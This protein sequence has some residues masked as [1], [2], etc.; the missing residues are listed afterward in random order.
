[1]AVSLDRVWMFDDPRSHGARSIMGWAAEGLRRIGKTVCVSQLVPNDPHSLT[2]LRDDLLA[3]QPTAILLANHPAQQFWQQI[4]FDSAQC[5]SLVWL[6]DD[7]FLMGKETFSPEEIVLLSDPSFEQGA[8][9]RGAQ[10]TMFLPVAAPDTINA[11]SVPEFKTHVAYVGAAADLSAMRNAL[12]KDIADYFDGIA[13]KKAIQQNADLNHLLSD[14]PLSESKR[15][16]LTGQVAY[17]VYANAN[18][19]HRMNYLLPLAD[20]DLKLYG[21]DA[22]R[23]YLANTKLEA[24]FQGGIDPLVDYHNLIRSVDVNINLRSLQGFSAPTHRDFLVPRLGGFMIA[25][26]IYGATSLEV[27]DPESHFGLRQ[28]P[29]APTADSPEIIADEVKEWLRQP[30]QR[31]QWIENASTIICKEHLFSH[32]MQ[33]LN[34]ALS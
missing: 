9:Q 23:P 16:T 5:A 18:R 2:Q 34:D 33:Q 24:C 4:G 22:W 30:H 10:T 25:S 13:A 11:Q 20:L 27:L 28:F 17:Y 29:W 12:S 15:I 26:P 21:N 19:I 14:F 31:K 8:K 6:F 3:F 7:P 1:M 32:R